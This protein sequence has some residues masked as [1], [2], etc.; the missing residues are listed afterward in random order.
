MKRRDFLKKVSSSAVLATS[1]GAQSAPSQGLVLFPSAHRAVQLIDTR[2]GGPGELLRLLIGSLS[3]LLV[4]Q[5]RL[6]IERNSERLEVIQELLALYDEV[7]R[8]AMRRMLELAGA[9]SPQQIADSEARLRPSLLFHEL[10]AF[11]VFLEAPI[12]EAGLPESDRVPSFRFQVARTAL[13]R[14]A[15]GNLQKGELSKLLV[16]SLGELLRSADLLARAVY[17]RH[18]PAVEP[19][20]RVLES[21]N[22]R[23]TQGTFVVIDQ[24]P[25][26]ELRQFEAFLR[27]GLIF[28]ETIA[29]EPLLNAP[30]LLVPLQAKQDDDEILAGTKKA[31]LKKLVAKVLVGGILS[32]LLDVIDEIMELLRGGADKQEKAE[33]ATQSVKD[34]IKGIFPD[35]FTESVLGVIDEL[36]K[37]LKGKKKG[38]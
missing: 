17:A 27:T 4:F 3:E 16:A 18:I 24:L 28:R 31:E 6:A 13:A 21:A 12:D 15:Q 34:L 11:E 29:F 7:H 9:L 14:I 35:R 25:A 22:A 33:K 37:L 20:L 2:T 10:V 38:P 5:K 32:D 26:D 30:H 23:V 19:L 36:L 1:A 8:L